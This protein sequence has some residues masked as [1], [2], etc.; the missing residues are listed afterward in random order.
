MASE[1]TKYPDM[2]VDPANDPRENESA[3]V[4][5]R[6]VL[7]D[8]LRHYRLTFE[9]KCDG[10]DAEQMARRSVEPST[11]SLLGLL[12]HLAKVEQIWFRITMAGSD[13]PRL[14]N[15]GANFGSTNVSRKIVTLI[16]ITSITAG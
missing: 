9:M 6:E 12:R 7:L 2:W 8:Y 16:A 5:E 4:S 15:K 10:L 13:I 1:A 11:L 14:L 3:P